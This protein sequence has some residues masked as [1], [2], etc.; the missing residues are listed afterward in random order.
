MSSS[1]VM[2]SPS[3]GRMIWLRSRFHWEKRKFSGR[4][5]T[6]STRSSGEAH[7]AKRSGDSLAMLLGEISPKISTTTVSTTVEMVGP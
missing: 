2:P 1:S 3:A 6:S 4:R 5:I 7:M